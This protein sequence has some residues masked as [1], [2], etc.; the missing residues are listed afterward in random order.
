MSADELTDLPDNAELE[1]AVA[2]SPRSP[3]SLGEVPRPTASLTD[4]AAADWLADY[5]WRP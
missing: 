3:A 5:V 4:S 2:G 1:C